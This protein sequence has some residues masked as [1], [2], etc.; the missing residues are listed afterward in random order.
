MK[1]VGKLVSERVRCF[2]T[3]AEGRILAAPRKFATCGD[4]SEKPLEYFHLSADAS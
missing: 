3:M 1:M 4:V 2:E